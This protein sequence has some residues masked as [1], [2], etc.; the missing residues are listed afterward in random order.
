MVPPDSGRVPPAPPYSGYA[1]AASRFRVRGCHPVPRAFPGLFRYRSAVP[2][3]SYYP[4][5]ALT[6]TVWAP[7]LS[8]TTTRGITV[9]FSSSPYLDVSV[10]GVRLRTKRMPGLQPGGLPHS[11]IRGSKPIRGSPRLFAACHVLHRLREPRHPPCALGY[12]AYPNDITCRAGPQG[13]RASC[14]C[15]LVFFRRTASAARR[16]VSPSIMSKNLAPKRGC[17]ENKGLE[18][19]TSSLQSWRSTN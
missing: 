2:W 12:F 18:P 6:R 14:S 15:A 10:R 1:P 16:L 4:A 13:R 19:L 7:P 5:R 8:L 11:D 3:A 17:V 9:V